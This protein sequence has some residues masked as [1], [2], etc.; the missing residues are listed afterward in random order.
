MLSPGIMENE[1]TTQLT[2]VRAS[3]GRAA[4]VGKFNWGPAFDRTKVTD[5]LEL[6][7]TFG[8]PDNL[9]A[10]Y[11]LSGANWLGYGNDLRVVRVLNKEAARNAT[12][13]FNTIE[14]TITNP[15]TN[16]SVGDKLIAKFEGEVVTDKGLV[17]KV[18]ADGEI[19]SVFIPNQAIVTKAL[20][21]NTYPEL[22]FGWTLEVDPSSSG[23]SGTVSIDR[24]H[25]DSGITVMSHLSAKAVIDGTKYQALVKQNNLP[26]MVAAYPGEY[27]SGL[28]AVIISKADYDLGT[29]ELSIYPNGGTETISTR[30]MFQ[31]GPQT[32]DQYGIIIR[33]DG[34]LQESYI[35]ST[36]RGDK[37]V[38][39]E[40]IFIDD[41]Y[42]NGHSSKVF[43]T[44]VGWPKGF[45]GILR[46]DGGKSAN[47]SVTEAEMLNGWDLFAD[48]EIVEVNQL[49]AG[50]V[51][52]EGKLF[53]STV[54]KHVDTIAQQ[55]K[56]CEAYISPPREIIVD[57]DLPIAIQNLLD[58][59]SG[60]NLAQESNIN[61]NST[62]SFIDGNYKYQYD[63][64]NGV[65]RW[66]PLAADIAGLSAL[67]DAMGRPWL[68]TA[69]YNRGKIRGVVKLAIEPKQSHRDDLYQVAINPVIS[70]GDSEGFILY[71]DKTATRTPT[72]FDRLNVRRLFNYLKRSIS[73]TAKYKLWEFNDDFTRSSFRTETSS[74]I[75]TIKDLGGVYDFVVVCDTGNNTPFIID[76]NEFVADFKVKP[77]R[78][79]NY[80]TLNYVATSTG[81]NFDELV[82]ST[83]TAVS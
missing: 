18:G 80:I 52:G 82:S 32:D 60:S 64:Y 7:N 83:G 20:I 11:F 44:S 34:M 30:S 6:L 54:M 8:T 27:G 78:S 68:P 25:D 61:I 67:T 36:K 71:G 49:I 42:M 22:E 23:V 10:D 15:G 9:T 75:Q 19:L 29:A 57:V 38:Y 76:R 56:D 81:A 55:R 14:T 73:G 66:V 51:A 13:V 33:R 24:I 46:F 79:I 70:A 77:A 63:R 31:Y 41:F 48:R 69:G 62:Y 45:S 3:T 1:S 26:P 43:G 17:T 40:N 50:A 72:P 2:V 35:L 16:Y 74:F 5:E 65:Y 37:D 39:N 59:R 58:W 4:L 28:E 12:P 21:S 53:A 47:E